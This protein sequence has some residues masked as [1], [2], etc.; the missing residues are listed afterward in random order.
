MVTINNSSFL[1]NKVVAK[2]LGEGGALVIDTMTVT[3]ENTSFD[4][5]SVFV[6]H[7][8]VGGAMFVTNS[9]SM[10]TK[11]EFFNNS[12]I[13]DGGQ[14]GAV[15]VSNTDIV[16]NCTTFI[17]NLLMGGQ[18]EHQGGVIFVTFSKLLSFNFL[19]ITNNN[20]D[21]ANEGVVFA[22]HSTLIL[23]GNIYNIL[24]QQ[25]VAACLL[26]PAI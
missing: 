19:K 26:F 5:N 1:G 18:Y 24:K 16:L 22:L 2:Q 10:I 9:T 25:W 8:G 23:S 14:G 15:F 12:V 21:V 20:N 6:D 7:D 3:L 4:N 11:S 13:A 17:G